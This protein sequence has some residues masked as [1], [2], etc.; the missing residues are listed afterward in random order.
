MGCDVVCVALAQEWY[1][2]VVLDK[3]YSVAWIAQIKNLLVQMCSQ[4]KQLKVCL[5]GC[6][7]YQ[8]MR[9]HSVPVF[10]P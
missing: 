1:V 10:V 6:V 7:I 3:T 8:A 4:L 9:L 2:S 5:C